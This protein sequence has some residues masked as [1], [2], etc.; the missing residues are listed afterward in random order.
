MGGRDLLILMLGL[1]NIYDLI[2]WISFAIDVKIDELGR[3][4]KSSF[5]MLGFSPF[6]G[7]EL[8]HGLYY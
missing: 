5:L 4:E 2:I 3:D 6:I 7:L 1:L 8:L